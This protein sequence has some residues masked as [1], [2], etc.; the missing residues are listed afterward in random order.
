M[1]RDQILLEG[2]DDDDDDLGG[3]DEVFGL[4]GLSS[5]S[6]GDEEDDDQYADMNEDDED[7]ESAAPSKSTKK[8]KKD[9]KAKGKKTSAPSSSSS[10]AD[11]D[12]EEETWGHGK[13]AYYASNADEID[14]EDEEAR[15]MEEQEARRLQGKALEGMTDADFGLEDDAVAGDADAGENEDFGVV[16]TSTVPGI[17]LATTDPAAILK[18]LEKTNPEALALARD[19][20]DTAYNLAKAKQKLDKCVLALLCSLYYSSDFPQA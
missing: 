15:E 6:E 9:A 19:W 5:D 18:H 7:A 8:S 4:Q 12:S 17:P 20:E 13:K 10:E 16:D 14:S 3:G 1:S 11:S 2:E